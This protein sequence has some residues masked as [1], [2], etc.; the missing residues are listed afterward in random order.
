MGGGIVL[1]LLI[2]MLEI[3]WNKCGL[4]QEKNTKVEEMHNGVSMANGHAKHS[5][6]GISLFTP[7]APPQVST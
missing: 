1:S 3:C 6:H 7:T 4:R 2:L 5:V